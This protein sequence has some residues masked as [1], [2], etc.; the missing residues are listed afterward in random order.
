MKINYLAAELGDE[1]FYSLEFITLIESHLDYLRTN[2]SQ[3]VAIGDLQSYKYEGD[4][5]GLFS[6]LRI[7]KKYHYTVARVNGY[8]NSNDYNGELINLIIP[9]LS[10]ISRLASLLQTQTI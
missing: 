4:L 2:V 3:T 7:E 5:Y 8:K 10:E 6:E 9:N 1:V